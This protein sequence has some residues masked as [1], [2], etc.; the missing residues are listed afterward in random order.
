MLT[1]CRF[2]LDCEGDQVMT[3]LTW[4]PR[5]FL[6]SPCLTQ[7]NLCPEL[8]AM[9]VESAEETIC[10]MDEMGELH[11]ELKPLGSPTY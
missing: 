11:V 6:Q 1:H 9:A 7:V 5:R 3:N 4:R 10:E 2:R 8:I